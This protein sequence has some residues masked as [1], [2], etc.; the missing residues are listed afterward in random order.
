MRILLTL[1][2]VKLLVSKKY[3]VPVSL[4]ENFDLGEIQIKDL[5]M[6]LGRELEPTSYIFQIDKDVK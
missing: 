1:E 4:V 3:K 5:A 2:D 6:G